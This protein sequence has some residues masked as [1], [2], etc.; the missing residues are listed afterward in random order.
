MLFG[1]LIGAAWCRRQGGFLV[2]GTWRQI[3]LRYLLGMAG[4]FLI[5]FGLKLIFS[6]SETLPGGLLRLLRYALM[7][8]WITGG[9]PWVCV[10][11]RLAGKPADG[12]GM[13]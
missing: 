4:V 7:G 2:Q 8:A 13:G 10:S 6:E 11:L 12:S 3:L 5:R 9:A 1:L